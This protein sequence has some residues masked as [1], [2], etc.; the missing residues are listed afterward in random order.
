MEGLIDIR[1]SPQII[2]I[3]IGTIKIKQKQLRIK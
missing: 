3:V 2:V 1:C